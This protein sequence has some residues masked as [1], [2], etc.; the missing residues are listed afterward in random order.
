MGDMLK[1]NH[2]RDDDFVGYGLP[3]LGHTMWYEEVLD[4]DLKWSFAL[5]GVVHAGTSDYQVMTL[6]DTR[7]FGKVLMIDGKLQS[8]E[9]DEFVY[10]ECIVHPALLAHDDPKDVFIMG[11]GEGSTAREV[12][13]H[14]GVQKVY[15]CDVD[16]QEIVHF[17]RENLE[18]NREAFN[19][20]RLR[21]IYNDAENEL[22][23]SD[24][25]WD[26]IVGD[27]CDPING[28]PCN[29]L[30][31]KSF[32]QRV[33]KPKLKDRGI[34]VTQA[35]PAG[36]LSHHQVFSPIYHTMK[37]VFTYVVAYTAHVPSFADTCGWIMGSDHPLSLEPHLL[38]DRIRERVIGQLRFLDGSYI[39]A[40]A[41]LNKALKTT[42]MNE[43]HVISE[44]NLK[45]L[46]GRGVAHNALL[47]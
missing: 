35:G 27:L 43:T 30:Y 41:H 46:H 8:A 4:E 31:T 7:P 47:N 36:V 32:Y 1:A 11:G 29:H 13:K 20:D 3:E 26:I 39:V 9:K 24:E 38:D 19:D 28:G 14:R 17:C 12:L 22:R 15:M 18:A 10:H 16:T 2:L 37:Q 42:L 33:L 45:F 44:D 34:F 25:K 5:N 23:L 21:V 40:S 6:L